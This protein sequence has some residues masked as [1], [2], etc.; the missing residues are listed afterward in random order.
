[1]S[2]I[3]SNLYA[4]QEAIKAKV[5]SLTVL[6]VREDM[7]PDD[8]PLPL[9]PDGKITPYIILRFGPRRSSYQGR[10]MRGA[11]LDEYW[12]SVDIV[13]ITNA[14]SKSRRMLEGLM[15]ELVGFK[16]DGVSPLSQR[17]DAGDPA[18]FVVSSN[19]TRPTQYIAQSRLRFSINGIGNGYAP[20]P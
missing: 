17:P 3:S 6:P 13:C 4:I 10:S 16:P 7:W 5:E 12:S 19:E 2:A 15:T 8:E 11:R 18:M 20:T 9:D 1:M 14:G